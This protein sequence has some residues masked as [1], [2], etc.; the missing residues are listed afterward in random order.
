MKL[1]DISRNTAS[2]RGRAEVVDPT[3]IQGGNWKT[4]GFGSARHVHDDD[5]CQL[6]IA[7]FM[8]EHGLVNER[9]DM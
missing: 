6:S 7:E 2:T 3:R 1:R 5:E 9:D 8:S 4:P